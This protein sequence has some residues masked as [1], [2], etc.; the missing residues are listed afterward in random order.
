[1]SMASTVIKNLYKDELKNTKIIHMIHEIN[2]FYDF[3][4]DIY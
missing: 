4:S 3:N 1:M 2:D